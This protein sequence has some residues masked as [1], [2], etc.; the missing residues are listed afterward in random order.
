MYYEAE[1]RQIKFENKKNKNTENNINIDDF[2]SKANLDIN[3]PK[4]PNHNVFR[5]SQ[6]NK[7][8]QARYQFQVIK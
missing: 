4:S 5:P 2:I 1:R 6:R 8:K 7:N 3:N